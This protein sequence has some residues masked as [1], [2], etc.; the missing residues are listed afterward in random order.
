MAN[1]IVTYD[2]NKRGQNYECITG[3]LAKMNSFH[4]QGSVW[5]VKSDQTASE[6]VDALKPC[7]DNNDSLFVSP[8][9]KWCCTGMKKAADWLNDN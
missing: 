1:Y 5:F 7:L 8:V 4:A 3:K 2:L 9:S 6:L